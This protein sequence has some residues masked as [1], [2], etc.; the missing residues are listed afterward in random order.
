MPFGLDSMRSQV[1]YWAAQGIDLS[2]PPC[3]L[4]LVIY[5]TESYAELPLLF[6]AVWLSPLLPYYWTSPYCATLNLPS[7]QDHNCQS[8][9]LPKPFGLHVSQFTK[10]DDYQT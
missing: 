8:R 3:S 2:D 9:D 1:S 4:S 6:S 5:Q 10:A 7:Q